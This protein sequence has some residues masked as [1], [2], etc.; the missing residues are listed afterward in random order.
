M[1]IFKRFFSIIKYFLFPGLFFLKKSKPITAYFLTFLIFF[2]ITGLIE[3]PNYHIR[4][5]SFS[6]TFAKVFEINEKIIKEKYIISI[7]KENESLIKIDEVKNTY[8]NE[9]FFYYFFHILFI[10]IIITNLI[11]AIVGIRKL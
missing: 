3:F 9:E 6:F 2:C 1:G 11:I 4:R 10:F 5:S 8:Y 7:G